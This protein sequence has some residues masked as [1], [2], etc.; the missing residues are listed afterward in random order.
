[1]ATT[2]PGST[3]MPPADSSS[4]D[5]DTGNGACGPTPPDNACLQCAAPNCCQAWANC[6]NDPTCECVLDCHVIDGG[7][8][9]SCINGC[10]HETTGYQELFFCGQQSCLGTC[11]WD[12][13]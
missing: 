4:G 13:C 1:M 3:T 5:P 6:M 10:G 12:C 9:N 7:S 11:E 8:L 2:D